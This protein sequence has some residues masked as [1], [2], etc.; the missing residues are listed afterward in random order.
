VGVNTD[1][2]LIATAEAIGTR[3]RFDV[4][5]QDVRFIKNTFLNSTLYMVIKGQNS[6]TVMQWSIPF[7]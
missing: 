4:V 2:A 6:I 3:E 5:F 7:T 1:G